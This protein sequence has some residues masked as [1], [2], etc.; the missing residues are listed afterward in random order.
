LPEGEALD[1]LKA[2]RSKVPCAVFTGW[3][4]DDVASRKKV[5]LLLIMCLFF[6]VFLGGYH[7]FCEFHSKTCLTSQHAGH[8]PLLFSIAATAADD[9]QPIFVESYRV[10]SAEITPKPS[11]SYS[12]LNGRAPPCES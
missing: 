12:P 10:V 4:I 6:S 3:E 11:I 1:I 7:H 9:I 2:N 5:T 8:E